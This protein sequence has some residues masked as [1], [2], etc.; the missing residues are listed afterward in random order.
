[1]IRVLLTPL[2][3]LLRLLPRT[4]FQRLGALLGD[5]FCGLA[6]KRLAIAKKNLREAMPELSEEQLDRTARESFRHHG[7]FVVETIEA[8]SWTKKDFL[9]NVDIQGL[10]VFDELRRQGKGAVILG[11]H[12]GN[13]EI[14]I[15]SFAARGMPLDIVVKSFPFRP[16]ETFMK[17]FRSRTGAKV[18]WESVPPTE[19]WRSFSQGRFVCFVLDQYMGPPIGI[20]VKFFGRE[21]GTAAGLALLTEKSNVAVVPVRCFRDESGRLGAQFYPPLE[22]GDLSGKKRVERL[23]QKTQIYNDAIE[24]N[25]RLEPSQWTWIHRRWKPFNGTSRWVMASLFALAASGIIGCA[26]SAQPTE[27]GIALPPDP[28]ITAP[29]VVEKTEN[30]PVTPQTVAVVAPPPIAAGVTADPA[31]V[32]VDTKKKKTKKKSPIPAPAAGKTVTAKKWDRLPFEMGEQMII[33][34]SWMGLPAGR[35]TLEVRPGPELAGRKT[36]LLWGNALSSRLMDAVLH[37]D[38]TLESYVDAQGIF[39]Y[40]F[41]LHMVETFQTKETRVSFDH[42]KQKAHYWAKRI[43]KKMGN[44]DEDRQDS[45]IPLTQDMWSALYALRLQDYEI[46][47]KVYVPVYENGKSMVA[48]LVPVANELVRTKAGVF[49]AWKI[50]L[51]LKLNNVLRPSGAMF[52]WLSDDNKKYIVKFDI[53]LNLGSLAGELVSVRESK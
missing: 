3:W 37:V 25:V 17:W 2:A 10:E 5:L 9:Q 19:F 52:L 47:K 12:L 14:S 1:M 21:A 4:W 35:A 13:W 28:Q 51:E 44:Q 39:P 48:E 6:P 23:Y 50:L 7:H 40:K 29:D 22:F 34:G 27:T 49:Q 8:I 18:L 53:K 24:K 38:N 46:G 20:P 15:L 36:I 26:S 11:C 41:L 30:P 43:S 31:P 42:P 16:M 33:E 32:P 45:I